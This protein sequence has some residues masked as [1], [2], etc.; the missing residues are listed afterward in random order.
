ML[1]YDGFLLWEVLQLPRRTNRRVF[2]L[3]MFRREALMARFWGFVG[4][5][6]AATGCLLLIHTINIYQSA[7]SKNTPD[8]PAERRI[9]RREIFVILLGQVQRSQTGQSKDLFRMPSPGD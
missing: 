6:P 2:G 4:I 3:I 7:I 1:C 5:S 9:Y 8:L